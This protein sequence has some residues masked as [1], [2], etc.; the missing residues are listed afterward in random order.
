MS[1]LTVW[2]N[3]N[4]VAI[5]AI[6]ALIAAASTVVLVV[7]TRRYVHLTRE[8]SGVAV[9]QLKHLEESQVRQAREG[10]RAFGA[11]ALRLKAQAAFLDS[12]QVR[13]EELREFAGI[14]DDDTRELERL[15]HSISDPASGHAALAAVGLRWLLGLIH[16]VKASNPGHGYPISPSETANYFASLR[17]A[18]DALDDIIELTGV[19]RPSVAAPDQSLDS[20]P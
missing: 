3:A 1:D 18:H 7:L 17:H 4:G 20:A 11:L 12:S 2:L 13:Q 5:Q 8:I 6:A 10:H 19:R 14:S 16:R 15:A 9:A